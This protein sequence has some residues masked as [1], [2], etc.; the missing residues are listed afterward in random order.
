MTTCYCTHWWD[1]DMLLYPLVGWGHAVVL[2]GEMTTCWYT[3]WWDDTLVYPLVRW[4]AGIPVGEMTTCWYTHWWD[5][6]LVYPLVKWQHAGIPIGEMMCWYTHW[7]DVKVCCLTDQVVMRRGSWACRTQ[8]AVTTPLRWSSWT[9]STSLLPPVAKTT[10]SS[11]QV[12][13]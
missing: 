8:T 7:W 12:R 11:S 3:H 13:H 6:L 4:F 10:L 9:A 1:D 5:D 2:I